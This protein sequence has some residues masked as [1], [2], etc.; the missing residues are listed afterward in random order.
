MVQLPVRADM[1]AA[2]TPD[3]AEAET[4]AGLREK[5]R[6][7]IEEKAA[8][9]NAAALEAEIAIHQRQIMELKALQ[10]LQRL[11]H[12]LKELSD[13]YPESEA[14]KRAKVMLETQLLDLQPTPDQ[15]FRRDSTPP[16]PIKPKRIRF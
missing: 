1:L 12:S 11:F 14:A 2:D 9:L 6:M 13:K 5:L 8:L 10:E 16:V 15:V 4:L 7:V 3:A